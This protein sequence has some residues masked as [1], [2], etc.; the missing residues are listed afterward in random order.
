MNKRRVISAAACL[1]LLGGVGAMPVMARTTTRVVECGAQS[2]LKLSGKRADAAEAITLNGH[3]ISV[4]GGRTWHARVPV[5]TVREW[6]A[7]YARSIE[8]GVAGQQREVPLPIGL[9]GQPTDLA[10]VVVRVK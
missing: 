10:M 1:A 8:V 9:L 6:S 4:Q 3:G 5:R 7:P 2:C